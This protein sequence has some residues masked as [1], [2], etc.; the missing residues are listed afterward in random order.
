MDLLLNCND[1]F[2]FFDVRL[3][4]ELYLFSKFKPK[5]S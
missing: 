3:T 4:E 5:T 2:L 1:L